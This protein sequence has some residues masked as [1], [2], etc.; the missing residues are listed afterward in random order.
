MWDGFFTLLFLCIVM[1]TASFLAGSLPLWL[2]L[3]PKQLR[4]ITALGTGVLVGTSLI[5]IIPE[6]VA[7]LYES[8]E[9]HGGHE[10]RSGG[11]EHA[12]RRI[13]ARSA[14][15]EWKHDTLQ[16]YPYSRRDDPLAREMWLRG[17]VELPNS[18]GGSGEDFFS[19]PDDGHEDELASAPPAQHN[20][21]SSHE[22][23]NDPHAWIGPSLVLGFALMYL[24]DTLPRQALAAR[25]SEPQRFH[26]SLNQF[27]FNRTPSLSDPEPSSAHPD[28]HPSSSSN[29]PTSSLSRPNSTT[30]GLVI[31]AAADGVALGASSTTTTSRLSF[32][33]FIALLIHKAPAAF[34]LTS[35]LLKQNLSKR[36]A[37][38]HLVIFSLSAPIG[39][40]LTWSL[41]N[42]LGYGGLP[43][44][45]ST[46]F[47]TG[48]LLLFSG[49]TFLYVAMH[50]MQEN[51]NEHSHEGGND[52]SGT[53]GDGYAELPGGLGMYEPGGGKK[54][55]SGGGNGLLETLVT[56]VGMFLPIL[57]TFGHSH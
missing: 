8:A 12:E 38:A 11:L 4:L 17:K 5:V 20:D 10:K 22:A 21:P 24:I 30:L 6:G 53:N 54:T 35:V 32:F 13:A 1:A 2:T 15:I 41:I 48:V 28:N 57:T 39:A 37:R 16:P 27:S 55:S 23:T 45:M 25:S 33:I 29:L 43:E 14:G 46:E 9:G 51:D 36:S 42:L 52:H 26:I 18:N 19:G 3:S 7:T 40:L 50:T 31:H 47:A 34:G 49:G 44:S 56:A